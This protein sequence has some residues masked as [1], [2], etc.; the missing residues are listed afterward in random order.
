M[1]TAMKALF[2]ERAAGN[3]PRFDV[4]SMMA[5]ADATRNMDFRSCWRIAA[6]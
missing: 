5:H 2:D 1:A 6:C 4:I 3:A